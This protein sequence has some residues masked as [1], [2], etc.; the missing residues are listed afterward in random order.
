MNV[1]YSLAILEY[2][3][4][5]QAHSPL[6]PPAS[7]PT[8]RARVRSIAQFIVSEIQPLQNTRLDKELDKLVRQA[9]LISWQAQVSTAG[10]QFQGFL[11][12][13]CR[14]AP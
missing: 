2:L 1:W 7:D 4:E 8:G 5:Q 11:E 3:E 6:L 13:F 9:C 14:H 12:A 10:T